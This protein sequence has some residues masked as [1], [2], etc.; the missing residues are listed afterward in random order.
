VGVRVLELEVYEFKGIRIFYSPDIAGSEFFVTGFKGYGA[1]GYIA[2]LHMA[3]AAECKQAGFIVTRYMPE[4]ITPGKQGLIAPFMLYKCEN[5]GKKFLVLVN[6]DIPLPQERTRFAEAIIRFLG[7][8]NIPESVLVGGF[9]ARFKEGEER[10]RWV[11]TRAYKRK[12]EAPRM[13][14]GLYVI[15]PL[16]LLLLFAEIYSHPA[17]AI[18]PYTEAARPNPRAA[19]EAIRIINEIYGL[20]IDTSKLLEQAKA[21][22]EMIVKLE[23]QQKEAVPSASERAYM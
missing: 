11:A 19:A 23:A 7:K 3:E 9:D 21:I 15:G 4:A 17:V 8:N 22:E 5:N 20:S 13:G 18:L 1:V 6:S 14:E 10:F 12:L 2:T 16:A